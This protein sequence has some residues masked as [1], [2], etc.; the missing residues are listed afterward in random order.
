MS[1]LHI[2]AAFIPGTMYNSYMVGTYAVNIDYLA[3]ILNTNRIKT[4]IHLPRV[5]HQSPTLEFNVHI[6]SHNNLKIPHLTLP[7]SPIPVPAQSPFYSSLHFLPTSSYL[8][9]IIHSF[10]PISPKPNLSPSRHKP[11]TQTQETPPSSEKQAHQKS[12]KYKSKSI[13]FQ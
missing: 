6:P 3:S 10:P 13:P 4:I 5:Y 8:Q 11:S 12:D 2:S 7:N 1:I 9:N